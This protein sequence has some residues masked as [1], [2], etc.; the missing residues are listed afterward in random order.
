MAVQRFR[1]QKFRVRVDTETGSYPEI[2]WRWCVVQGAKSMG[3]RAKCF[4]YGFYPM[5]SA[6]CSL[7][8]A[9][10][11]PKAGFNYRAVPQSYCLLI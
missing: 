1:V 4:K 10:S 5:L 6:L 11:E 2:G 9:L 3:Q 8:F 7:G